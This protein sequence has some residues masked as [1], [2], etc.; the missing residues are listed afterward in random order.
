M[1]KTGFAA[2]RCAWVLPLWLAV[3]AATHPARADGQATIIRPRPYEVVQREGFVPGAAHENRPGGPA[4]GFGMVPLQADFAGDPQAV[5]ECRALALPRAFGRGIGWTP[6]EARQTG[7][8]WSGVVRLPAGGW[9][10]VEVR[11]R[12]GDR[13]LQSVGVEPFGVGEVFVIAGQSYAGGFNDERTR[14]DD[15]AGRVVAYD[16]KRKSWRVAHDPQPDVGGGGTIWPPMANALLP[17][18]RVPI[19]M[20]NVAVGATSSRQWLPQGPLFENLVTA[21]SDVGRFRAVLWQQGESDVIEKTDAA[22]YVKNLVAIRQ[23]AAK[24]W[25]FELPWLLAKS[26]LHPTVY[27]DPVNEGQIR[28]AIGRLWRLP[29]FRPGP[30]TDILG[31]ENRGDMKSLRHFSPIGQR[32]AGLLWFAAIWNELNRGE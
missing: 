21:G 24:K 15:A 22:T 19:G 31:G 18:V 9:Y 14:I 23:A 27:N 6:V 20:A 1:M 10:R 7:L 26:T 2:I 30:D 29:G 8:R 3:V 13:V 28:D 4:L 25:G 17:M 16:V 12:R 5:M 32:R 11:W